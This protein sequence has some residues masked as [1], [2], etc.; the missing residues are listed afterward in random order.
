MKITLEMHNYKHSYES[1]YE[2]F[3]AMELKEAFER[4]M[5]CAGYPP[6]VINLEDGKYEFVGENEQIVRKEDESE[7]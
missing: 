2:D 1:E 3:N 6:S 5:V 7:A 4:L